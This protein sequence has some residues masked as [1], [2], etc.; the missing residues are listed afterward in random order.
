M[1]IFVQI[2]LANDT[3][4]K[5][6]LLGTRRNHCSLITEMLGFA[7]GTSALL[8]MTWVVTDVNRR[9]ENGGTNSSDHIR[10]ERL[11]SS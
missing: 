5:R 2:T 4:L 8:Q 1:N 3:N 7:P 10:M 6:L 11:A 9:N